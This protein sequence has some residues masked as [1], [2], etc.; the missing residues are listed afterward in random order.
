MAPYFPNEIWHRIM[1]YLVPPTRRESTFQDPRT[2]R[3]TALSSLC[4]V[5]QRF[6]QIAQPLLY[7]TINAT[8]EY[9]ETDIQWPGLLLRTIAKQ[10]HLAKYIRVLVL[11]DMLYASKLPSIGFPWDVPRS[12]QHALQIELAEEG[13]GVVAI[14]LLLYA[15]M[16]EK[17]IFFRSDVD[18]IHIPYILTGWRPQGVQSLSRFYY[19]PDFGP[20]L[21]LELGPFANYDLPCLKELHVTLGF[22]YCIPTFMDF[23]K[24]PGLSAFH[25]SYSHCGTYFVS[26]PLEDSLSSIRILKLEDCYVDSHS[27][28]R[29]LQGCPKLGIL[30]IHVAD[31][32]EV[33]DGPWTIDLEHIGQALRDRGINLT[34]LSLDFSNFKM[35]LKTTGRIGSL[36]SISG[37]RHLQCDRNDLIV[38]QGWLVDEEQEHDIL[39]L[40]SV[41][42]P[43]ITTL[44]IFYE[45]HGVASLPGDTISR[46]MDSILSS[47]RL[48]SLRRIYH[49]SPDK[50]ILFRTK[51]P[52]SK[53]VVQS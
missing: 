35:K 20:D 34:D 6:H 13:S 8:T 38:A 12:I 17:I 2:L 15:T 31:T 10:P 42:P 16:V 19:P 32:E 3:P 22:D 47:G 21:A 39:P 45:E 7:H 4:R 23:V 5:S 24:K 27:F 52:S 48:Q 30:G 14:V 26:Q 43:S 29:L 50:P 44:R 49:G 11:S 53:V 33:R 46:E 1:G 18:G 36:C 40:E 9:L 41:L 25:L 37:L 51:M 28:E